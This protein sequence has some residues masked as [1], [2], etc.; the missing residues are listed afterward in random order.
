VYP[1]GFVLSP[2]NI[3]IWHEVSP[4]GFAGVFGL[5]CGNGG[6][7][8]RRVGPHM[9]HFKSKTF[10]KIKLIRVTHVVNAKMVVWVKRVEMISHLVHPKISVFVSHPISAKL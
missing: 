3:V 6:S 4:V 2:W 7:G 8:Y 5:V 10:K 9:D 1:H